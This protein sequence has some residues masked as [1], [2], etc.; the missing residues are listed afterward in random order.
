MNEGFPAPRRYTVDLGVAGA[1]RIRFGD[2]HPRL[3]GWVLSW[4]TAQGVAG[5]LPQAL[6]VCS[7]RW[8]EQAQLEFGD[9]TTSPS[10]SQGGRVYIPYPSVTLDLFDAAG[11]GDVNVNIIGRPVLA[12]ELCGASTRLVGFVHTV[13]NAANTGLAAVPTGAQRYWAVQ[14]GIVNSALASD[15]TIS[16]QA[17]AAFATQWDQYTLDSATNA[18]PL[19]TAA[20][21]RTLP[22]VDF[23][24]P[25]RL[26]FDNNDGAQNSRVASYFEFD[27]A[28]G[29]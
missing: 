21:W 25:G 20:P 18:N 6:V 15:I 26:R 5:A 22:P 8:Y 24:S 13:V 19:V 11:I 4:V 2:T 27:F 9:E 28:A 1:E 12:G 16:V 3:C 29:R 10:I 14:S 7:D 23:G 17:G